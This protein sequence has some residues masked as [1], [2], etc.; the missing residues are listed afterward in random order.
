MQGSALG[1][2]TAETIALFKEALSKQSDELAKNWTQNSTSTQGLQIYNL[3]APSKKLFPVLTPLRNRLPRVSKPGGNALNWKA[4]TAINNST[5]PAGVSEG[6]RNA[7]ALTTT[8]EFTAPYRGIGLEDYVTFEA[9][10]AG[11]GFEDIRAL[12][13][14]NLLKALMIA[15]ERMLLWGNGSDGKA[16]GTT[17]TPSIA[18]ASG[19]GPVA[20]TYSVICIALTYESYIRSAV[21]ATGVPGQLSR[22]SAGAY[23]NTDT[24]NLGAAAQSANNTVTSS[25]GNLSLQVWVAAVPG[26]CAYAW[27]LGTAGSE[28]LQA[29]TTV[30]GSATAP[31]YTHTATTFASNQA[32]TSAPS[33]DYSKDSLSFTGIMQSIFSANTGYIKS[34]DGGTLHADS[35]GGITEIEDMLQNLYDNKRLSPELLV[36][37]SRSVRDI[38]AGV[39]KNNT[40]AFKIEIAADQGS[41]Q[42]AFTGGVILARYLGKFAGASGEAGA[43]IPVMVHPNMPP[44]TIA[45]LSFTLPYP[46]NGVP[47]CWQVATRQEYYAI[48]WP[49]IA[50]KYEYGVYA[51]ELLQ[52]YAPFAHGV[53]YN[54]GSGIN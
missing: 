17:P 51:D 1:P 14:E 48:E 26:A 16:L 37:N 30:N 8:Q 52:S 41:S 32:A 3:E 43:A 39:L 27:Y 35:S 11:Q 38:I 25:G 7:T 10:Y 31:A 21:N 44:G 53:I 46:V 23:S 34:L 15:E 47:T 12:A 50:R 19:T 54:I 45:A 18:A 20:G 6:N 9:D 36:V 29:I 49:R 4:V 2:N 5:I 24:V 28:K 22:A 42:G 33:S 13:A 40:S